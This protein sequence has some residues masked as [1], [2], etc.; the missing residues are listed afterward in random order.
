MSIRNAMKIQDRIYGKKQGLDRVCATIHQTTSA[1][2][3]WVGLAFKLWG[4]ISCAGALPIAQHTRARKHQHKH[5][6]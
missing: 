1:T 2:E 3:T 5:V 6:I 4:S